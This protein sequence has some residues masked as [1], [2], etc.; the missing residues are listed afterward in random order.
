[1]EK[2]GKFRK[3]KKSSKKSNDDDSHFFRLWPKDF[4]RPYGPGLEPDGLEDETFE[5]RLTTVNCYWFQDPGKAV[6]TL[7]A[8]LEESCQLIKQMEFEKQDWA[9]HVNNLEALSR[10]IGVLNVKG[11]RSGDWQE[12]LKKLQDFISDIENQAFFK[13]Y[14]IFGAN[15]WL[16]NLLLTTM[17]YIV[18]NLKEVNRKLS[19]FAIE[20]L[21]AW[22]SEGNETSVRRFLK[23]TV[24]E[25]KEAGTPSSSAT[26][27]VSFLEKLTPSRRDRPHCS[28]NSSDSDSNSTGKRKRSSKVGKSA[29]RSRGKH[30]RSESE[31]SPD[32]DSDSHSNADV[33]KRRK[34][35]EVISSDTDSDEELIT[36]KKVKA[37]KLPLTPQVQE[38]LQ[39][40][41]VVCTE[42]PVPPAN[43]AEEL[44]K[45]K[46]KRSKKGSSTQHTEPALGEASPV[47]IALPVLDVDHGKR[48][49][50]KTVKVL[51]AES[52]TPPP[53][54]VGSVVETVVPSTSGESKVKRHKKKKVKGDNQ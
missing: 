50:S 41:P 20:Q 46:T 45:R 2:K 7:V 53:Q 27:K 52:A 8:T 47:Q 5:K 10:D 30:R 19:P 44:P 1:M 51:L 26:D 25:P 12:A 13:Y 22:S 6:S 14:A 32:S 9:N 42:P 49:K 34:T 48:K 43:D 37:R 33:R 21:K 24:T 29:R 18:N 31:S 54:D 28:I 23:T 3:F 35:K 38:P 39:Q 36:P 15:I 4:H 17:V 40:L 11:E 16:P